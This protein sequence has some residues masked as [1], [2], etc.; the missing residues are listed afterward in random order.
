M[1]FLVVPN[2]VADGLV[3]DGSDLNAN[4]TAVASW[5]NGNVGNTNFSSASSDRLALTKYAAP[6]HVVKEVVS[7]SRVSTNNY[8]A[9]TFTTNTWYNIDQWTNTYTGTLVRITSFCNLASGTWQFQLLKN[10]SAVG[11]I[12]SIVGAVDVRDETAQSPTVAIA[13]NDIITVQARRT[14]SGGGDAINMHTV[15]VWQHIQHQAT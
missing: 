5:A 12:H 8:V 4:F 14:T 2:V 3:A 1:S 9:G 7:A 11:N 13:N 10:G 15:K 6:Y